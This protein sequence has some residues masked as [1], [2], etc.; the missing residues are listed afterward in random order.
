MDH[1]KF[2]DGFAIRYGGNRD[3]EWFHGDAFRRPEAGVTLPPTHPAAYA[4]EAVKAVGLVLQWWEMRKQGDLL[5]AEFEERRLLWVADML[6]TWGAEVAKEQTLRLDSTRYFERELGRLMTALV[7][8]PKMD[9]PGVLLLQVERTSFGLVDLNRLV[10][11]ELLQEVSYP[12]GS[13]RLD[14]VVPDYQPF[15]EIRDLVPL[16]S[17]PVGF[18]EELKKRLP[19]VFAS[20][21]DPFQE[22]I[23]HAK[24]RCDFSPIESL[25]VELRAA[26]AL[27]ESAA[28]FPASIRTYSPKDLAEG[29]GGR[30]E[31]VGQH[32][33]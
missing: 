12:D 9:V 18:I 24:R 28:Q 25:M 30:L 21:G 10:H 2:G 7:R 6:A 23:R 4:I 13:R 16:P 3:I 20:D 29:A 14:T 17:R 8:T 22:Y 32:A 27:L 15:H 19:F 1:W 5:A 11:G 26:I 33:E 31:L